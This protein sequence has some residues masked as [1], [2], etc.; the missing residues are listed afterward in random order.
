MSYKVISVPYTVHACTS[1]I[2]IVYRVLVTCSDSF[3]DLQMEGKYSL[4]EGGSFMCFLYYVCRLIGAMCSIVKC[5]GEF[6]N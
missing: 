3:K 6:G 4:M 5:R 2:F 1:C